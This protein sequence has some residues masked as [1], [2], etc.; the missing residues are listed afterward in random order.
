MK[1]QINHQINSYKITIICST[2]L[3]FERKENAAL[4]FHKFSVEIG[5]RRRRQNDGVGWSAG[6]AKINSI[7]IYRRRRRRRRIDD[8]TPTAI[9]AATLQREEKKQHFVWYYLIIVGRR[10]RQ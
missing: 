1:I 7:S 2:S 5:Q 10:C 6:D 8:Q 4:K 3:S 9:E